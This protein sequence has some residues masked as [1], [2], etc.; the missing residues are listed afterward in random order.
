M[1]GAQARSMANLI[2]SSISS[3]DGYVND[4][5]GEFTWAEPDEELHAFVNEL[6]RA[7]GT[8]LYGRRMYEVMA[9]WETLDIS[10]APAVTRDY[11]EIWRAT[12]K[13][14]YSTTLDAVSTTRTTL[15]RSFD[16]EAIRALKESSARGIT[17]GGPTLAAQAIRAGLVDEMHLIL[18]PVLVGGGTA[19][20]P[21]GVRFGLELI[22]E[23]RF[24]RGAVYLHYRIV[25]A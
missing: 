15:Q 12:E 20:L 8:C 11:A 21:A 16:P 23:R 14:V 17:I 1:R 19:S 9:W 6:E 7:A 10:S 2:Y 3:L 4:D 13:V 22:G 24:A 25:V 18:V 5:R